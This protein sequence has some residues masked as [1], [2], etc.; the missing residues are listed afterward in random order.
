MWKA[1]DSNSCL[2]ETSGLRG[3]APS[4]RFFENIPTLS[5]S[6]EVFHVPSS[7]DLYFWGVEMFS[8]GIDCVSISYIPLS[9]IPILIKDGGKS[10]SHLFNKKRI[11]YLV[12]SISVTESLPFDDFWNEPY[13]VKKNEEVVVKSN[14]FR[15]FIFNS[16]GYYKIE[17][18]ETFNPQ[19][20]DPSF[21]PVEYNDE[22]LD[23][24]Y[25]IEHKFT[26][27]KSKTSLNDSDVNENYERSQG[28]LKR[29]IYI[30]AIPRT[31][32][33]VTGNLIVRSTENQLALK[34][35]LVPHR[36][37]S[38]YGS[39]SDNVDPQ[40]RINSAVG[41]FTI[42]GSNS[43]ISTY[44]WG[45]L[46]NDS[47]NMNAYIGQNAVISPVYKINDFWDTFLEDSFRSYCNN[48]RQGCKLFN[49]RNS[50]IEDF[51]MY[52]SEW[53]LGSQFIVHPG[54]YWS[55]YSVVGDTRVPVTSPPITRIDELVQ[56]LNTV[57][58]SGTEKN[59]ILIVLRGIV[60]KNCV[61]DKVSLY[62][63]FH[64]S[65]MLD[66]AVF[67]NC[68]FKGCGL[69]YLY[70]GGILI[71]NCIFEDI[72]H[73]QG[74][75]LSWDCGGSCCIMGCSQLFT[76]R[77]TLVSMNEGGFSNNI[78]IRN[79]I[80]GVDRFQWGG[81]LWMVECLKEQSKNSFKYNMNIMNQYS[82]SCAMIGYY[83]CNAKLNIVAFNSISSLTEG[84]LSQSGSSFYNS[85]SANYNV[86]LHNDVSS[87]HLSFS[88]NSQ[89]NRFINC[90][91]ITPQFNYSGSNTFHWNPMDDISLYLS[92]RELISLF[93]ALETESIKGNL[94]NN[95][96]LVNYFLG[97]S[98]Y[99]DAAVN[100]RNFK[101]KIT[102]NI[103]DPLINDSL[104]TSGKNVIHN[105]NKLIQHSSNDS[106]PLS[107][108]PS[109]Q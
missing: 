71:K 26:L 52:G 88:Y 43:F 2:R 21:S 85:L 47:V 29:V 7:E 1:Y 23:E 69:G 100:D 97:Q 3:V 86:W 78:W 48:V 106:Y 33:I 20:L 60:F 76:E 55:N 61:F 8:G 53:N 15:S 44:S 82:M 66:G 36:N 37:I 89:H 34:P 101:Y 14:F 35:G 63:L 105:L 16:P 38:A 13:L 59:H 102:D 17:L 75:S 103:Q 70:S 57:V 74:T 5:A 9:G 93:Y 6:V 18:N 56:Y 25:K 46:K 104:I 98:F 81:E 92:Q 65:I 79:S 108:Y 68:T 95:C 4:V 91:F 39:N 12:G 107:V 19:Y 67:E 24:T 31:N 27:L 90:T 41:S 83:E 40:V 64:Q 87:C 30:K 73:N 58:N 42:K 96:F 32:D 84:S 94:I 11:D 72:G 49:L 51:Y 22:N 45:V 77:G 80:Y 50:V 10:V 62:S 99:G 54:H 109:V 28:R